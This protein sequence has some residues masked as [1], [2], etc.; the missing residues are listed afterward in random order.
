[1]SRMRGGR[2]TPGQSLFYG[3]L[4]LVAGLVFG[5]VALPYTLETVRFVAQAHKTT[6]TVVR[7]AQQNSTFHLVIAYT[8]NGQ[9]FVIT[10]TQGSN[11][12]FHQ[13]NDSVEVLYRPDQPD[14]GQDNSFLNIWLTPALPLAFAG[15][16]LLT[17]LVV[18]ADGLRRIGKNSQGGQPA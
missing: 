16:F 15:F 12:P 14:H 7:L 5:V 18:L 3:T 6:G 9:S 8:V 13:V 17:G 1:M 2:A 4:I 10:D 11:P